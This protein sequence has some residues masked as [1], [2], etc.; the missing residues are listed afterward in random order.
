MR[1]TRFEAAIDKRDSLKRAEADGLVADSMEV[2]KALI[3]R[4]DAGELTLAQVQEELKRIKRNAG[5]NGLTTRAKQW[6]R[7]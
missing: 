4:M 2:R 5:K 1:R 6:R 3:A 7:G